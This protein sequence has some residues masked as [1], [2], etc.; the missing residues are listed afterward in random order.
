VLP[1]TLQPALSIKFEV[2][3]EYENGYS[4]HSLVFTISTSHKIKQM[5]LNKSKSSTKTQTINAE[6]HNGA[7]LL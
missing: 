5:A 1:P 2:K 7:Y 6:Q 4:F 3:Q